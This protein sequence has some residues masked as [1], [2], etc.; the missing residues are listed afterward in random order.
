MSQLWIFVLQGLFLGV[1]SQIDSAFGNNISIDA[2]CV[3]SAYTVITWITYCIYQIGGYAYRILLSKEKNCMLISVITSIIVGITIVLLSNHIPKIYNLTDTQDILFSKCLKVHGITIPLLAIGE[4]L[5]NYMKFQCMNKKLNI[6]NVMFY[7]IMIGLDVII[8]INGGDLNH[9]L[10]ATTVAYLIYDITLI[11]CSGIL[12][13]TDKINI[14]DIKLCFKHGFNMIT[15]RVLGKIATLVYNVFASKLGTEA[16]AV[17]SICYSIACFTENVTNSLFDYAV[18]RLVTIEDAKKKFKKC[19]DIMK[20]NCIP[21]ALVSYAASY[22]L[23]LFMHG[24]VPITECIVP[25][26]VYCIQSFFIQLYEGLR[27]Y[28]TSLRRSD[29]LRW[30]GLVGIISRV[31]LTSLVHYTGLGLYGFA[32]IVSIDFVFRGIYFL[33]CHK[34]LINKSDRYSKNKRICE[35]GV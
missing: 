13:S 34:V 22:L 17:H 33:V 6:T 1:C 31:P 15:D 35:G 3:L 24:D 29:L 19:I 18:V 2:I 26:A 30:A 10:L 4:Y 23:L 32:V 11:F 27:G 28:L 9:L 21:L 7:V 20:K 5:F 14:K 8:F 12:K 25:L 16:F